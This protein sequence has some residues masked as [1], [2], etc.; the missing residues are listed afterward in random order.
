LKNAATNNEAINMTI[1]EE[2]INI[3]E[4]GYYLATGHDAKVSLSADY[5]T[6]EVANIDITNR[7]FNKGGL[8]FYG[9]IKDID[10]S[11]FGGKANITGNDKANIIKASE[12]GATMK[13]GA[14][15]DT[16]IGGAG[17]DE[18]IVGAGN[19]SVSN[20]TTGT[21]ENADKLNTS[22]AKLITADVRNKDVVFKTAEGRVTVEGA[23]DQLFK[24]Q[25]DYTDGK[26]IS[27][28]VSENEIDVTKNAYYIAGGKEA[29]VKLANY[30]NKDSVV[31][32]LADSNHNNTEGLSFYGDIKELDATGYKGTASLSGN[33][34][35]NIITAGSGNSTLW[36][37]QG[38]N[39]TLIGGD[40]DD[41]FI[42]GKGNGNDIVKDAESNDVVRLL[43]M[44]ID[45]IT[46]TEV[47]NNIALSIN[48]GGKVMVLDGKTS[49]VKYEIGDATYTVNNGNFE[50]E[51]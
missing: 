41:V 11:A 32:N 15:N 28:Q 9:D 33:D 45:D 44:T 13:G 1:S 49:G 47:G 17:T 31:A 4:D 21:D 30:E 18:F 16:F 20:F 51:N 22:T 42:Y 23:A 3:A 12:G 34:K 5:E 48:D 43:G 36:G 26:T 2:E 50:K 19:N 35:N 25:N 37:G 29:T 24:F 7:D 10:A 46:I 40:G 6:E 14:G 27:I 8:S 39:D 38:G